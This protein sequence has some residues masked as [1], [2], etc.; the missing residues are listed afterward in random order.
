MPFTTGVMNGIFYS[1]M[2]SAYRR[3]GGRL[4]RDISFCEDKD[5]LEELRL[6][7]AFVHLYYS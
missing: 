6:F 2:A 1:I 4:C 5:W 7:W 3:F